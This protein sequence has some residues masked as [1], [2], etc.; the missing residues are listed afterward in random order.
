MSSGQ[1]ARAPLGATPPAERLRWSAPGLKRL[2]KGCGAA[3]DALQAAGGSATL[4]QLARALGKGR[5]RDL[6]RRAI[7]RLEAA[8]VVRVD[9][10]AVALTTDWREALEAAR[11]DGCEEEA[12]AVQD[13]RDRLDRTLFAYRESGAG[14]VQW[15]RVQKA[16]EAVEVAKR[17]L[18]AARGARG[19]RGGEATG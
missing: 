3:V 4:E 13:A 18:R 12:A 8:A 15:K 14:E 9:G 1:G 10:D 5:P 19:S 16:R 2:G 7:A 6:R 11:R 17:A